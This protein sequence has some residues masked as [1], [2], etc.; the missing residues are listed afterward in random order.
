MLKL[1][2]ADLYKVFHRP[3]FYLLLS[4][5][6]ALAFFVNFSIARISPDNSVYS[7]WMVVLIYFLSWPVLLM[8]VLVDLVE[9]EEY[10]DHTLKNAV[11]YGLNRGELYCSQIVVAVILGVLVGAVALGAYCG[12]SLLLLKRGAQ[13]TGAFAADF[14]RRVGVSCVGYAASIS[15]AAFLAMILP[16][17]S[18]F[19]FAFYAVIYL[20]QY[21]LRLLKLSGWSRFLLMPQFSRIAVGSAQQMS[22]SLL[23]FLVTAAFLILLGVAF[24]RKKDIC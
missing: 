14:F 24:F 16:K 1:I 21:V 19:V 8:P 5:M 10:K 17:N 12:S 4:G 20:P 22:D 9:S 3:S 13:F 18:L 7:S 2:H 6:A 11:S 23:V 15:A